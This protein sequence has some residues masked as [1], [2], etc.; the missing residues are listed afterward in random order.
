L[1]LPAHCP[2]PYANAQKS[3]D[4]CTYGQLHVRGAITKSLRLKPYCVP[5][6]QLPFTRLIPLI[7]LL[8]RSTVDV[9]PHV[10]FCPGR[11][12]TA[13][14]AATEY[15]LS[16]VTQPTRLSILSTRPKVS[17]SAPQLNGR[18]VQLL[19]QQQQQHH[20]LNDADE[21]RTRSVYR[22][23]RRTSAS[24]SHQTSDS[25]RIA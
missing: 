13:P 10:V 21:R 1:P 2:A 18:L 15:Q 25:S 5:F 20:D 8:S 16:S 7:S 24:P 9:E 6:P 14:S 11:L 12:K 23:D 19:Q 22:C 17:K 3:N 4:T